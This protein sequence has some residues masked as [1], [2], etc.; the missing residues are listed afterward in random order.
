MAQK[1]NDGV[2]YLSSLKQSAAPGNAGKPSPERKVNSVPTAD[3]PAGTPLYTGAEKR[4]SPRYKCAGSAELREKGSDLRTWTTFTDISMHG[5]YVEA[6]TTYPIGTI[7]SI[8]LDANGHQVMTDGNVRVNYPGLGMGIAFTG[9]NTET[10]NNLRSLVRAI[11]RPSTSVESKLATP[12]PTVDFAQI[13]AT[14]FDPVGAL[15]A[16]TE[17]FA[18]RQILTRDEFLR[19]LRKYQAEMKTESAK[20]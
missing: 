15:R 10:E 9:A 7:L 20:A 2:S 5:C 11:L 12:Q 14:V 17:Y 13:A 6:A 16:V 19:L 3:S 18:S 4:R 1:P 8:R